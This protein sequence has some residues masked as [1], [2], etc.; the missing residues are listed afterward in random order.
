M[1]R[2]GKQIFNTEMKNLI[3]VC[4]LFKQ[5]GKTY[6]IDQLMTQESNNQRGVG[7]LGLI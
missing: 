2:Q 6:L 1:L 4:K 3:N 7:Y 5:G